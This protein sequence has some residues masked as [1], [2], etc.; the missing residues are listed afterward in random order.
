[1]AAG[2][3]PGRCPNVG[4]ALRAAIEREAGGSLP[5]RHFVALQF[6]PYGRIGWDSLC[7]TPPGRPKDLP[8]PLRG[9][10]VPTVR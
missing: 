6:L 10:A 8:T 5:P 1:M 7:V 4:G 9:S 2:R 3:Q